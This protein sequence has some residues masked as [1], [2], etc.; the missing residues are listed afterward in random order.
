MIQKE[1]IVRSADNTGVRFLK[2]IHIEK[3][4]KKIASIGDLI[5]IVVKKFIKK[6]NLIKKK[7]YFGLLITLK[8]HTFRKNGFY[9]KSD[10][11]Q[12]VILSKDN[13][14]FLGTRIYS[15]IYKELR[16][17]IEG[18]KNISRYEKIVSL[19]KKLI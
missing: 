8:Q 18:K 12:V 5:Y 3:K 9:I 13:K 17:I 14:Q 19:A 11:N 16:F 1:T 15:P 7:I 4:K 6:K 10:L 2:C